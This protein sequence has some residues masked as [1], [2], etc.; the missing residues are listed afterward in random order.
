MN[1]RRRYCDYWEEFEARRI[2]LEPPEFRLAIA[3]GRSNGGLVIS[4]QMTWAMIT[5]LEY[6]AVGY[7]LE[8]FI[9]QTARRKII[10]MDSWLSVPWQDPLIEWLPDPI[11]RKDKQLYYS[12]GKDWQYPREDVLNHRLKVPLWQGDFLQGLLLGLGS[13]RLPDTYKDRAWITV[14]LG[15]I[16]Q[17]GEPYSEPFRMRLSRAQA[18]RPTA[19]K[20]TRRSIFSCREPIHASFAQR[21]RP[22]LEPCA[23]TK[24]DDS[25]IRAELA[26][27][28]ASIR[29]KSAK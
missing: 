15:V 14:T 4:Q 10:I 11:N 12:L 17:W 20:S 21:Y 13:M 24:K 2:P 26:A 1:A 25:Q 9:L 16:D 5:E 27:S 28:V 7:V 22:V 8:P 19:A 6:G 18:R 29:G 23:D 3:P